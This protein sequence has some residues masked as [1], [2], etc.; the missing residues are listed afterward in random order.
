M[1]GG[2][3]V[4]SFDEGTVYTISIG[5][6]GNHE[7]IGV[8]TYAEKRYENGQFY[9]YIKIDDQNLSYTAYDPNGVVKDHFTI[10]KTQ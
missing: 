6:E 2:K 9:Q 10:T 1:N 3:V 8:E 5:I 4:D 7:D